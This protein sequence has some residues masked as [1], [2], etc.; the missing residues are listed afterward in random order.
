MKKVMTLLLVL[1]G[2]MSTTGYAQKPTFAF[3][4]GKF[5]V[6]QF[7]DL[8]WTP[9]SPGCAETEATIRAVLK[10]EQPALAVLSGD[11]VTDDPAREGWEAVVNLF[12]ELKMPF[13]VTMG[14]HDAEYLAKDDIYDFLMQSPYYVGEKG[15]KDIKGCGNCVLPVQ[16]ADGKVEAVLYFLDSNDY[17]PEKLYGAYDWIHFD[18]I[19]WYRDQSARFTQANGGQ[20]LPAL[21]FFH[22]PLQE[23]GEIVGDNKTYGTKNEGI[24]ASRLNSGMFT[25][26]IEMQDVMGAFV[27]HDHDNDYLG[28]NKGIL[29][30]FGRVTGKDGA[31]FIVMDAPPEHGGMDP[32]V[33]VTALMHEAG[34]HAPEIFASDLKEGFLLLSDLGRETYLNVLNE[35]NAFS[36]M[37]D[38]TTALVAWQKI[39]RPGV[40]PE[41]NREVLLREVNLFPE[42]YVG[43]HKGHTFTEEEN[44]WW[45]MTIDAVIENNLREAKVFVHRDF[46]PRNLMVSDPNPGVIDNRIAYLKKNRKK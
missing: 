27:G 9:R 22:I 42:W 4:D 1:L 36:L 39:S 16:G 17:Q 5:K 26:F 21:A 18:Q 29:L 13:I 31:T 25:S 30:A 23:Y 37:D 34:L 28:I 46:M 24:A 35:E 10:A 38:A 8:H 6:V 3:K 32:F 33:R 12:N 41:Y 11:V 2:W 7:T 45:K 20:P 14:N 15:P 40:L 43:R 19:A 44:R